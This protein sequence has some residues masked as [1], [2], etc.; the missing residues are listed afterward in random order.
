MFITLLLT[1]FAIS[2]VVATIVVLIF[3]KPV[4]NILRRIVQ[5]EISKAW[6]RYLKFAIYVV[7]I[8]GGVRIWSLERY[9]TKTS[10]NAEI[11]QLTR[12]RWVMEI[13][14]SALGTLQ[15]VTWMLLVFFIFALIAY[16]IVR[17]TE[18][19]RTHTPTAKQDIG[20]P[21]ELKMKAA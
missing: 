18:S 9:F 7:G 19:A 11:L 2:F 14:M 20:E 1:T 21:N 10:T 3:N 13:F 6:V 17:I 4:E 5:D 12:E 16:V 8:S 15:S